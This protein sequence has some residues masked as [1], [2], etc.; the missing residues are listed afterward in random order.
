MRKLLFVLL[1]FT[2]CKTQQVYIFEPGDTVKVRKTKFLILDYNKSRT[3][4][5]YK[6]K[7][8][9]RGFYVEYFPQ[10]GLKNVKKIADKNSIVKNKEL[11]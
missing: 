7:D 1:I 2:S 4:F 8:L 3:G 6:A 5:Y 11:Q 10:E 9:K